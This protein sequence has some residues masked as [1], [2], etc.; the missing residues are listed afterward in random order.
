MLQRVKQGEYDGEV[1]QIIEGVGHGKEEGG[2]GGARQG[3]AK[4]EQHQPGA[5]A[6]GQ[7][8]HSNFL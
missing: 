3:G 4:C 2:E 6:G 5:A 1:E 8:Q 7:Q